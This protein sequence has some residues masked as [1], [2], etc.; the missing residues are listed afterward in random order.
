MHRLWKFPQQKW[1]GGFNTKY[2]DSQFRMCLKKRCIICSRLWD[3]Y[4]MIFLLAVKSNNF[5]F[6]KVNKKSF[7]SED[8]KPPRKRILTNFKSHLKYLA[9]YYFKLLLTYFQL[10]LCINSC[11][12]LLS[13]NL[14][15][16]HLRSIPVSWNKGWWRFNGYF[17]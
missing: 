11:K 5:I 9:R 16:N 3:V 6:L 7:Q 2:K 1:G 8:H 17:W 4:F 12:P 10:I 15:S 14:F 13:P